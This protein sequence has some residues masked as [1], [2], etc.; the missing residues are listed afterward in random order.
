MHR[1]FYDRDQAERIS[2]TEAALSEK[3]TIHERWV[4]LAAPEGELWSARAALAAEIL[5]KQRAV[6]DLGC[7]TM[8]LER[9]LA[10]STLYRPVDVVSRDARTVICDLNAEL[11]PKLDASAVVCLG[12]LEYLVDPAR[13]MQEL[14]KQYGTCVISYCISDSSKPMPEPR[15][16]HAWFNEFSRAETEKLFIHAGWII[17]HSQAIDEAQI[18]WLLRRR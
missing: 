11:P 12:L 14:L 18:I 4:A 10:K 8:T 7:G 2:L 15:R 17:E 16:S 9:Y 6:V 1:P 5:G 3:R 13:L